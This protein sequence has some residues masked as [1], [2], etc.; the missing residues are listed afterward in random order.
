MEDAGKSRVSGKLSRNGEGIASP[1]VPDKGGQGGVGG[2]E[3]GRAEWRAEADRKARASDR[4]A[5]T[6]LS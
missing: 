1:E 3:K 5:K 2:T 6:N 4:R